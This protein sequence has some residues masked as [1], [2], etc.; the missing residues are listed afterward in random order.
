M[1][2]FISY[3]PLDAMF[4]YFLFLIA[5]SAIQLIAFIIF[6]TVYGESQE[7]GKI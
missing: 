7:A 6:Y 1:F 3:I 2:Y 4:F 5:T